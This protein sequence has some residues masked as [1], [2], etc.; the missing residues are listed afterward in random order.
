MQTAL[1]KHPETRLTEFTVAPY[2][3]K[4]QGEPSYHEWL[5]EFAQPPQRLAAFAQ[6]LDLA[7][8]QLN[9]YYDDWWQ[10]K[11]CSPSR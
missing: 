10:A 2:V 3:S 6:D 7:L 4:Q 9:T 1:G 11:C 8:R 5:I